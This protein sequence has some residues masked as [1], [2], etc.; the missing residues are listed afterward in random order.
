M[1][2]SSLVWAAKE[3]ELTFVN[4]TTTGDV[5][6]FDLGMDG[7]NKNIL[8]PTCPYPDKVYARMIQ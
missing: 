3:N 6:L 5:R 2:L 7:A 1:I 8:Y 4:S